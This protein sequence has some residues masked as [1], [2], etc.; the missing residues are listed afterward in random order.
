MNYIQKAF[1]EFGI[2]ILFSPIVHIKI[3]FPVAIDLLK[4]C[5]GILIFRENLYVFLKQINEFINF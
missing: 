1:Y 4:H 3:T 5:L 2:E